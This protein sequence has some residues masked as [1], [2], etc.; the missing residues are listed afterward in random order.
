MH[1]DLTVMKFDHFKDQ[2]HVVSGWNL[3]VCNGPRN[4]EGMGNS[5]LID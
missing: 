2:R 4:A 5:C 3:L 1:T